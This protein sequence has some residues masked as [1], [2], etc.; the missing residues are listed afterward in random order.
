LALT[1]VVEARSNSRYS[2]RIRLESDT[3][4][5][6]AATYDRLFAGSGVATPHA[7]AHNRHVYHIYAIRTA[8]RQ[9]WQDAL[10]A[11]GIQTGIHYPRPVHL[12]P[13]Y[14][15]LGYKIGDLPHTEK[16]ANEVLS[17]PMVPELTGEQCEA[18]ATAVKTLAASGGLKATG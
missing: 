15:D 1:T 4:K 18:V 17:L 13:A 9:A 7:A 3:R 10:N 16:A 14:A 8:T 6:A 11:Q 5:S 12:L 2:G